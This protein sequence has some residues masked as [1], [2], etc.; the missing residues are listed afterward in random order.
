MLIIASP[1]RMRSSFLVLLKSL[2]PHIQIEQTQ[3]IPIATHLLETHPSLLVL[4]DV[5]LPEEQGWQTGLL[6]RQL[7]LQHHAMMLAHKTCQI[8][9]ANLAQLDVLLLDGITSAALTDAFQV[10]FGSEKPGID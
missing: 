1:G 3:D 10:F 4:I 9:R 7:Y 5:D 2:F 6:V 8:D